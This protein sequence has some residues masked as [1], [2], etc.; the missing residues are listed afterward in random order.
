MAFNKNGKKFETKVKDN[1]K[2]QGFQYLTVY[3]VNWK[4]NV[5]KDY[6]DMMFE[7]FKDEMEDS[8]YDSQEMEREDY[9]EQIDNGD[10]TD[11]SEYLNEND[12]YGLLYKDPFTFTAEDKQHVEELIVK[13][14]AEKLHLPNSVVLEFENIAT[15][16]D[17]IKDNPKPFFFDK[18]E[19]TYGVEAIDYKRVS[20]ST[21]HQIL[22]YN[23]EK[24]VNKMLDSKEF[25]KYLSLYANFKTYNAYN[26]ALVYAQKSDATMV[27]GAGAWKA[28]GRT[29]KAGEKAIYIETATPPRKIED[30]EKLDSYLDKNN[31]LADSEKEKLRA[32]FEKN[33]YAYI[34]YHNWKST[35]VFD[36]SQ[37][38]GKD[39]TLPY[40]KKI[41]MDLDNY[42][43]IGNTL[44]DF[45]K[46]KGHVQ[47]E[48]KPMDKDFE[49]S[50]MSGVLSIKNDLSEADTIKTLTEG[51]SEVLLHG[52][53]IKLSGIKSEE[54]LTPLMKNLENCAVAYSICD[55][56]GI[57]TDYAFNDMIK[58]FGSDMTANFGRSKDFGKLMSRVHVCVQNI[59]SVLDEKVFNLNKEFDFEKESDFEETQDEQ[60]L[61]ER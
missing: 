30:K 23:V 16:L 31:Y 18:I 19:E 42:E 50:E 32:D 59:N 36:I 28:L 11:E 53:E 43:L 20:L 38:E 49:Y 24:N 21:D 10:I 61:D 34:Q 15:G 1:F 7:K 25:K 22:S 55:R 3:D 39:L 56:L 2:A 57:V 37:T 4:V 29:I 51:A 52:K 44:I 46:D 47:V 14:Y 17:M 5:P 45:I 41:N 35:P 27:K 54:K 6:H 9:E 33:G 40:E 26:T 12:E 48:L 8:Y 60:E 58:A 13:T